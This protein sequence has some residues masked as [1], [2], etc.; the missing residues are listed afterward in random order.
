MKSENTTCAGLPEPC[1]SALI[2]DACAVRRHTIRR[3]LTS[4]AATRVV[5]EVADFDELLTAVEAR[6][7]NVL[8]VRDDVLR[9]LGDRAFDAYTQLCAAGGPPRILLLTESSSL[10][11]A[12]A[13]IFGHLW[14]CLSDSRVEE[15]LVKAVIAIAG[16]EAWFSRREV[17]ELLRLRAERAAP[18]RIEPPGLHGVTRRELEVVNLIVRGRTNK[19]IAQTMEISDLTVKT[20]V[21]NILK[22]CGLRRRGELPDRIR[23][24]H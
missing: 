23:A 3:V 22:K 11:L 13:G 8:V 20:H 19:E 24:N 7:P 5:A 10:A 1:V 17:T 18:V 6:T 2:A 21:Q 15:S 4:A 14:G 16:G 9:V 12:H